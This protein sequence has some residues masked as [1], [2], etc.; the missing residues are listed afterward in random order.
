MDLSSILDFYL[1]GVKLDLNGTLLSVNNHYR[2]VFLFLVLDRDCTNGNYKKG[3]L[4]T[5]TL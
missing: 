4:K 2:L 1:V 3:D 5:K